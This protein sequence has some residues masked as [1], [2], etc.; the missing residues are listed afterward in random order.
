[1]STKMP[2]EILLASQ[3]PRRRELVKLL[4]YP[5]QQQAADVDEESIDIPDPVRNVQETAVLKAHTITHTFTPTLRMRTILLAADTTVAVDGKM[6]NKPLD[7]ADA[8]RMLRLLRGR[9][10]EVLTGFVLRDMTSKEEVV[11]VHT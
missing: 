1:M 9:P 4:G 8:Q 3:S 10:H 11:G 2:T 7:A 5:V 6:L